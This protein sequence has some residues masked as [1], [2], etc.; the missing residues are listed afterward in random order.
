MMESHTTNNV[1]RL[2]ELLEEIVL[3]LSTQADISSLSRCNRAFRE[4]VMPLL[5]R[6]LSIYIKDAPVIAGVLQNN[7]HFAR[8]CSTF[9]LQPNYHYSVEDNNQYPE[10]FHNLT[11]VVSSLADQAVS[12]KVF[13]WCLPVLCLEV[14]LT[15]WRALGRLS[16]SLEQLTLRFSE[17]NQPHWVS[18][19]R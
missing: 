4:I 13:S 2:P 12:V 7:P 19:S 11:L 9:M 6:N 14:P 15:V 1:L 5:F 10:W 17:M 3:H 16:S 8:R 18:S